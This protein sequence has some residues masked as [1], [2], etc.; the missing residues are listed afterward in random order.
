ME[1]IYYAI[2]G[3][4]DKL[5][6]ITNSHQELVTI[7]T[8]F[9]DKCEYAPLSRDCAKRLAQEETSRLKKCLEVQ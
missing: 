8:V 9:G 7:M 3:R 4:K 6:A 5:K 2:F 1:K